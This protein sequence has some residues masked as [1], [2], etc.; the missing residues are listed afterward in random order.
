LKTFATEK[1]LGT[2]AGVEKEETTPVILETHEEQWALFTATAALPLS[3]HEFQ[4]P[5]LSSWLSA[6]LFASLFALLSAL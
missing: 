4:F 1:Y 3:S 5:S 2:T 6:S